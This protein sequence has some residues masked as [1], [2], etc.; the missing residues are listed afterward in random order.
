MSIAGFFAIISLLLAIIIHQR[1]KKY[2]VQIMVKDN[3]I[4]TYDTHYQPIVGDI[5]SVDGKRKSYLVNK[6]FLFQTKEIAERIIV[7]CTDVSS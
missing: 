6:R 5:I 1:I 7:H 4:H 2:R 3:I